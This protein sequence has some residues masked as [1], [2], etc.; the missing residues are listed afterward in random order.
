MLAEKWVNNNISAKRYDH[1]CLQLRFLV[2]TTILNIICCYAPQSGLSAD[3]KDTF[4]KRVSSI[5]ASVP[6]EEI[7]VLGGDFIGHI[8]QHSPG[9]KGVHKGNGYGMKNQ[10][11]LR[12]LHFCVCLLTKSTNN[13][14]CKGT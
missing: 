9:F 3:E 2:G 4:Y 1:C 13:Y 11:G 6:E 8:G 5:V 7:L 10:D 14:L 12:I